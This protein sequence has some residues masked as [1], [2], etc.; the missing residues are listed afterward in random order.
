MMQAIQ[1][2][3][4]A[5]P[6]LASAIPAQVRVTGESRLAAPLAIALLEANLITDE[7]LRAGPNA[8]LVEVFSR[9]DERDLSM[10]ALSAWW[11]A[12]RA[13]HQRGPLQ[14]NLHVTELA[15]VTS[16]MRHPRDDDEG[17]PVG[18]FCMDRADDGQIPRFALAGQILRLEA[19]REGF[20]QTVL[21]VLHDAMMHFPEPLDPWRA[22]EW[23]EWLHW[24]EWGS[25]EELLEARREDEGMATVQEV[26]DAGLVLTRA[27]FHADIPTWVT[28]PRR[29]L[30]R[31]EIAAAAQGEFEVRVIAACDAIAG[32]VNQ[33]G[34]TLR[35]YDVG[36]H[37]T[38][39]E[40]LNGSVVLLWKDGDQ[41]SRA[42]DDALNMF[43]EAGEYCELIDAHP[44]PMTAAGI[45]EYQRRTEQLLQL[46][47]LTE[48]LLD[49]IG[50]PL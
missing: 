9:R 26:I 47:K 34:W 3:A 11:D 45:Q 49:L 24:S 8:T 44:V 43:G 4:L 12:L 2:A 15:N 42:I 10:R 38:E 50:E 25:D 21:A 48:Q 29:V 46:A 40:S 31:D 32:L 41:I 35:P 17:N 1:P 20:G 13:K 16:H 30:T 37:P 6:L 27:M 39:L 36:C 28:Y 22:I 7:M 19:V 33:P 18:W 23:A 5:L 14:W